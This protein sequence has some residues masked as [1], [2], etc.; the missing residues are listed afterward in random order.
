[1]PFLRNFFRSFQGESTTVRGSHNIFGT[2]RNN[3]PYPDGHPG[4][5]ERREREQMRDMYE[6]GPPRFKYDDEEREREREEREEERGY[7]SSG[8]PPYHP[9][10][11]HGPRPYYPD[12][13]PYGSF[14][15]PPPRGYESEDMFERMHMGG[16]PNP[17]GPPRG[18]AYGGVPYPPP[19]PPPRY[20]GEPYGHGHGYGY[21]YGAPP[22]WYDEYGPG[23]GYYSDEEYPD[24]E[25]EHGPAFED[26]GFGSQ[27]YSQRSRSAGR[28]HHHGRYDA[29][30]DGPRHARPNPD[31]LPE[32]PEPQT[33]PDQDFTRPPNLY[34]VLGLSPSATQEE[35]IKKGRELRISMHPDK[36]I[37]EG[38]TDE[39][40][41][42]INEKAARVGQAADIL[43]DNAQRQN[44]DEEVR[45]WK[46]RKKFETGGVRFGGAYPVWD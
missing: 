9:S 17:R 32:D 2:A 6:R 8:P 36:L 10:F 42:D 18:Y 5:R 22:D 43:G 24:F 23:S 20:C 15:F 25:Y 44:Y 3:R 45:V 46:M 31:P 14:D 16:Y 33:G 40:K 41:A 12:T 26:D 30:S 19:P 29:R 11:M 28:H 4:R 38:T 7:R 27:G 34:A 1:M 21:G 13:E 35:I 39:E 37:K